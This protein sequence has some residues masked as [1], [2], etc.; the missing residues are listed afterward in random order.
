[1]LSNTGAI[2]AF[3][4]N[5][6]PEGAATEVVGRG[7]A[8]EAV[9]EAGA[10]EGFDSRGARFASALPAAPANSASVVRGAPQRPTQQYDDDIDS[11]SAH[12]RLG[13]HPQQQQQ[14]SKSQQQAFAL[15]A[16][17][18][19]GESTRSQRTAA[20]VLPAPREQQRDR[21]LGPHESDPPYAPHGFAGGA[22]CDTD[23]DYGRGIARRNMSAP[24]SSSF[25]SYPTARD[26]GMSSFEQ[27]QQQQR[28]P[29]Q[30]GTPV[31]YGDGRSRQVGVGLRHL[32]SPL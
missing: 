7:K 10:F 2:L 1:M 9:G 27:H 30:G 29:V 15:S 31:L 22:P 25:S 5:R 28:A 3:L 4:R 12:S 18:F 11:Y 24:A 21:N 14:Q 26:T 16:G 6:L 8:T 20:A 19:E 17:I 32:V 13:R 23:G